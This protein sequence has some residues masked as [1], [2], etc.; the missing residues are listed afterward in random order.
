V[1]HLADLDQDRR[2]HAQGN[3]REQLIDDPEWAVATFMRLSLRMN[4]S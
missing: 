1:L 4:R 3:S 2:R